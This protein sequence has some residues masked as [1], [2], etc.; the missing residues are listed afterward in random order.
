MNEKRGLLAR[1][2]IHSTKTSEP[3]FSTSAELIW[4]GMAEYYPHSTKTLSA[5][6]LVNTPLDCSSLTTP[7]MSSIFWYFKCD[8]FLQIEKFT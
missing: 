4:Q 1:C 2:H 3:I 7:N 5:N 8:A 6:P